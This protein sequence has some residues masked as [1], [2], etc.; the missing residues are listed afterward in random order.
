MLPPKLP[1]SKLTLSLP[2]SS[3][4]APPLSPKPPQK[5]GSPRFLLPE[6]PGSPR[7]VS[8]LRIS[9]PLHS[10]IYEDLELRD[11][12]VWLND[13]KVIGDK[14]EAF[15]RIKKASAF[16]TL[17]SL[18]LSEAP[19][20]FHS[21]RKIIQLDL[22]DNLLSSLPHDFIELQSLE[23]LDLSWNQFATLPDEIFNLKKLTYLNA[24]RNCLT[25]LSKRIGELVNLTL[26]D[27]TF[28]EDLEKLPEELAQLPNLENILITGTKI[29]PSD[30]DDIL[31]RC[32]LRRKELDEA[33]PFKR[34][35]ISWSQFAPSIPSLRRLEGPK[36]PVGD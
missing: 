11:G 36:S 9:P 12:I 17:N 2:G 6:S 15:D 4:Q 13:P 35:P 8:D 32:K 3:Q 19:Y 7:T 28:N 26:L 34:Q 5:S 20:F 31:A 1:P 24:S 29:S 16:L 25:D 10:P 14:Q 22:V 21:M 30:R 23:R 33:H 18:G 27:L